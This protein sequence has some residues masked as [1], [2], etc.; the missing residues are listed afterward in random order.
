M[1]VQQALWHII[2]KIH[3]YDF[4]F[5]DEFM[6]MIKT[7]PEYDGLYDILDLSICKKFNMKKNTKKEIKTSNPYPLVQQ[8]INICD[9]DYSIFHFEENIQSTKQIFD[10]ICDELDKTFEEKKD[11]SDP[12]TNTLIL[13]SYLLTKKLVIPQKYPDHP[14]IQK[15]LAFSNVLD[16]CAKKNIDLIKKQTDIFEEKYPICAT[17]FIE[18]IITQTQMI[19]DKRDI[20]C[21]TKCSD[22]LF[23]NKLFQMYNDINYLII[24]CGE[25]QRMRHEK[26]YEY[27]DY[28]INIPDYDDFM[29]MFEHQVEIVRWTFEVDIT[30]NNSNYI[31][32]LKKLVD[33]DSQFLSSSIFMDYIS[34][35]NNN[36]NYTEVYDIFRKHKKY[37]M[38]SIQ[39]N[40][41]AIVKLNLIYII[42]LSEFHTNKNISMKN[43]DEIMT[44]IKPEEYIDTGIVKNVFV[45]INNIIKRIKGR[46]HVIKMLGFD[47]VDISKVDETCL[48]CLTDIDDTNT[49]TV[50]CICCRKELGHIKCV[51]QWIQNNITCPNCRSTVA[52]RQR[53]REETFE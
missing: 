9:S 29:N 45:A 28:K 16:A 5:T 3:F 30:N 44:N 10:N 13:L 39:N 51:C 14:I 21:I 53:L 37:I 43:F 15:C 42:I 32:Y 35:L 38:H 50:K 40:R 6:E 20:N 36:K 17:R 4:N 26:K 25:L 46:E 19:N 41:N 1:N 7:K 49:Q 33:E 23:P 52:Q 8:I 22:I 12:H 31:S 2:E 48:I 24:L 27:A 18:F 11:D 34:M 47:I